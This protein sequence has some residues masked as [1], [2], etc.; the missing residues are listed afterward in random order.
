[1]MGS[2]NPEYPT[3]GMV[4]NG[5]NYLFLKLLDNTY[6]LSNEFTIRNSGDLTAIL[7]VMKQLAQVVKSYGIDA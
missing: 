7:R 5:A 2:P 4:T 1:M 6:A 3:F